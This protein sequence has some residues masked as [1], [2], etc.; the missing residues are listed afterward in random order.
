M[1][2]HCF[3]QVGQEICRA[4]VAGVEVRF[5]GDVFGLQLA[6]EFGGALFEAKI[7]IE[8]AVEIDG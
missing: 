2:D 7:V 1:K 4:V 8:A 3:P 5:V 6:V